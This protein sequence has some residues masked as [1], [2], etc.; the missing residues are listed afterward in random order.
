MSYKTGRV[1]V[2]SLRWRGRELVR[3]IFVTVRD[4]NWLEVAP[5]NWR[6]ES[7]PVHPTIGSSATA[8]LGQSNRFDSSREFWARHTSDLVDFEWQGALWLGGDGNSARFRV[9]G[10]ALRDME[11]CRLGLVL[12]H[13]VEPLIGARLSAVGPQGPEEFIVLPDVHPQPI[14]R[15]LPEAM[16]RPFSELSMTLPGVGPMTLR[17]TGDLFELEDQRNWGDASFK[18]YCTPLR[19]GFP[20]TIAAGTVIQQGVEIVLDSKHVRA[21]GEPE[22]PT[23]KSTRSRSAALRTALFPKLGRVAPVFPAADG[24]PRAQ[25]WH[26]IRFDLRGRAEPD[27]FDDAL[28]S[29]PAWTKMELSLAVDGQELLLPAVLNLLERHRGRI[30][31]ILLRSTGSPLPTREA[32]A[33]LR[34]PLHSR[35]ES[36]VPVLIEPRGYFVEFN[37]GLP[38]DLPVD[39]IAFP[40]SPTVHSDDAQTIA[41]NASVAQ[42]MVRTAR[43]LMPRGEV[44][45]SPLALYHPPSLHMRFPSALIAPWLVGTLA[46]AASAGVASVT[47]ADD[48][49]NGLSM[50]AEGQLLLQ[51]LIGLAGREVVSLDFSAAEHVHVLGVQHDVVHVFIA[52]LSDQVAEVTLSGRADCLDVAPHSVLKTTLQGPQLDSLVLPFWDG[53]PSH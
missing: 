2:T 7:E 30:C 10:R 23:I 11:V 13:P 32:I 24:S 28:Q 6:V 47:L 35:L 41:S 34:A 39:G 19:L 45:I 42:D 36:L 22:M 43:H 46:Q 17:F 27:M 18:S 40:L 52:N 26:H 21:N 1:D 9:E 8:S 20:R 44:A 51:E 31:T 12:L 29:M 33:D 3:R 37:R 49:V 53:M 14:V 15:G 4:R 16:L 38:F 25:E 5:T 48:V 50:T